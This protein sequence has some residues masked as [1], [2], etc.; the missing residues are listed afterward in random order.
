MGGEA[1]YLSSLC[2]NAEA[3]KLCSQRGSELDA[4]LLTSCFQQ[5]DAVY[6]AS[7]PTTVDSTASCRVHIL[8]CTE[9]LPTTLIS[10]VLVA[11]V[12]PIFCGSERF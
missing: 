3:Q 7:F 12:F 2:P 6:V 9:K 11:A 1:L 4:L 10:T 5:L 8:L